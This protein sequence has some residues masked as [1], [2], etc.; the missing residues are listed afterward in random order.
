MM[1]CSP[2]DVSGGA[3][4]NFDSSVPFVRH[5]PR[6]H[7]VFS[8][9]GVL[10]LGLVEST[11]VAVLP[12]GKFDLVA[13]RGNGGS[14]TLG[15]ALLAITDTAVLQT[16]EISGR[17]DGMKVSP[18]GHYAIIAIEKGG[19]GEIG[20]KVLI[21]DLSGGAGEIVLVAV[22]TREMLQALY[23][24]GAPNP[25]GALIEPEAIGY[26][27]DSSFALVTIQDSSTVAALDLTEVT[28]AVES[29]GMT[30][31]EIGAAALKSIVALPHGYKSSGA[32]LRGV[33]PDGLAVSPDG[34]FAVLADETHQSTKH[35][36]A[37]TVLDLRGGLEA[38]EAATYP[39]F[40]ID[41][42]LLNHTG[43]TSTPEWST[44]V[45]P[46]DADKLPRL[47]P[48]SVEIVKRGNETIAVLVLERYEASETQ[49]ANA[50]SAGEVAESRGSVLFLE[51]SGALEGEFEVID[52]VPIGE[53]GAFLEGIDSA[54]HGRWIF[55]SIS[56]GGGDEGTVAR[57]ELQ[58]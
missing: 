37:I 32:P 8:T 41:T 35:L 50:A 1:V 42:T 19:P 47:D 26:A 55:V 39:I 14:N 28:E 49:T 6:N 21:Y 58:R 5:I 25:V 4:I 31:E 27:K 22:I 11:D 46:T 3:E 44:T 9:T 54:Q 56:N 16:L 30:P 36:Q 15:N 2:T 20:G 57:L 10:D 23:P 13:T 51:V 48:A 45:Y 40:D 53:P 34:S 7:N 52:R 33:Q 12:H 24:D 38:I 18:D 43:L 17:P 29:G